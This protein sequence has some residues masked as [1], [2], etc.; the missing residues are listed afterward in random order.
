MKRAAR[1]LRA[2]GLAVVLAGG[3]AACGTQPKPAELLTF[4]Q[5]RLGETAQL[6]QDRQ[7]DL[8]AEAEAAYKK[9]LLAHEDD[10][11]EETL[12]YTR[13]ADITW[14]TAVARSQLEDRRAALKAAQRDFDAARQA[15][16]DAQQRKTLAEEGI[17]RQLR[18]IETRAQLAEAEA[19]SRQVK[20]AADAKAKVDEAAAKVA[21]AEGVDAARHAVGEF[22]KANAGLK[23]A[24]EQFGKGDYKQ[25]QTTAG[26][27]IADAD[28]AIAAAKPKWALEQ[29]M[30]NMEARIRA[31]LDAA[32]TVPGAES[33]L[34]PRGAVITLRELFASG[35]T[36]I[37][38][39]RLMAVQQ[40]AKIARDF[41][42]F[43]LIVEGHTDNRG[44]KSR[45]LELSEERARAVAGQIQGNG[46]DG[47]RITAIGRGDDEPIDDNSSRE[48]RARNRRV[49]VVFLRP[50]EAELAR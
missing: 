14:Q 31:I 5:L 48:G 19:R 38:T 50:T 22:N 37:E 27:V 43:R 15:Q 1:A 10:E 16:S 32:A 12:H 9:A 13:L 23:M 35:K 29:K 20:K 46:V 36:A 4:E 39:E 49:D 34:E 45:N 3:L 26:F 44:R 6:V 11:P 28:A 30:R 40:T 33:R 17:Q 47:G 21:E 18:L 24:L 25:A 42:E 7:P 41:A 8:Y 2:T